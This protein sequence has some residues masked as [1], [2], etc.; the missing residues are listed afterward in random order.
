MPGYYVHSFFTEAGF[1]ADMRPI[2]AGLAEFELPFAGS[3]LF[4]SD[5]SQLLANYDV[6]FSKSHVGMGPL[7]QAYE[8][9]GK[10][11]EFYR[12]LPKSAPQHARTSNREI[13]LDARIQGIRLLCGYSKSIHQLWAFG[14]LEGS[15]D[16]YI[17]TLGQRP[18]DVF[19]HYVLRVAEAS[20]WWRAR[21][22]EYVRTIH[23]PE[24]APGAPRSAM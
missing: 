23:M 22:Y 9:R 13:V 10:V 18:P 12:A 19:T 24:W 7:S 15:V 6:F 2:P 11:R 8:Y 5:P 21:E 14:N 20:D 17:Q 1:D 3:L 4:M 16:L